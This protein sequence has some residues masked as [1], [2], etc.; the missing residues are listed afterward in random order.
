[1][2]PD[3]AVAEHYPVELRTRD[4]LEHFDAELRAQLARRK[5]THRKEKQ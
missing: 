3:Q 2:D 1:M 5:H 4:E